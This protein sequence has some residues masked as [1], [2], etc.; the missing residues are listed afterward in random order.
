MKRLLWGAVAA[1]SLAVGCVVTTTTQ[2]ESDQNYPGRWEQAVL[3]SD[4]LG[5]ELMVVREN[6]EV[7][8]LK[9]KT[10]CFWARNYVGKSVWLKW[11]PVVSLLMND[12]GEI[13]EFFTRERVDR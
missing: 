4:E 5:V 2:G 9:A 6:S 8:V 12:N 3:T 1:V 11:G 10:D 7:W 13:C